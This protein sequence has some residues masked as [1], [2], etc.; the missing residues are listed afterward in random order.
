M[1]LSSASLP[2]S[3]LVVPT[4]AWL[5]VSPCAAQVEDYIWNIEAEKL[6]L[7]PRGELVWKA[8]AESAP[9]GN[10]RVYHAPVDVDRR[11]GQKLH[12]WGGTTDPTPMRGAIA[13]SDSSLDV[14]HFTHSGT[15]YRS[16]DH[17]G[18]LILALPAPARLTPESQLATYGSRI[19]ATDETG[20]FNDQGRLWALHTYTGVVVPPELVADRSSGPSATGFRQLI[21]V[22]DKEV[23][24]LMGDGT[25]SRFV[26]YV[27]PIVDYAWVEFP[28]ATQAL[29][30]ARH[31]QPAGGDRLVWATHN[32]AGT[33]ASFYSGPL[34][35]PAAAILLGA[36]PIPPS[37]SL[38]GLTVADSHIVYQF[39]SSG[40]G[41]LR[42]RSAVS[43]E[44]AS[45][46]IASLGHA[47]DQLCANDRFVCWLRN[48]N[49]IMRLPVGAA[50]ITRNLAL[51]GLE[52]IQAIQSPSN[53]VPLVADKPT[54]VRVLARLLASSAGETSLHLAPPVVLHGSRGGVPL[55]GSPLI[56]GLLFTLPPPVS[57]DAPNRQRQD[58]GYWFRLPESWITEGSVVLRAEL[59]P[60][61]TFRETSYA[62]NVRTHTATFTQKVPIGL[63]I[64]PTRTH[65]GTISRRRGDHR[66][67]FDQAA[68][69]LPTSSLRVEYTRTLI[70]ER[71][72]FLGWDGTSPY[73]FTPTDDD[74]DSVLHA[75]FWRKVEGAGGTLAEPGGFD[76]YLSLIPMAALQNV[77]KGY[78]AV[79]DGISA[80]YASLLAG[81]DLST[82]AIGVRYSA[83]V[84][85]HELGH[86]YGRAHVAGCGSPAGTD[87]SY[88]YAGGTISDE[89]AGHLGF[90]AYKRR[91]LP[92][93]GTGD[94]MSYCPASW[95]SDY[96]WKHIHNRV[97]TGYGPFS[98]SLPRPFEEGG[99]TCGLT[100]G[101]I[102]TATGSSTMR[103]VFD[104]GVEAYTR[105]LVNAGDPSG[106]YAVRAY[107][108]AV[109]K[110][111]FPARLFPTHFACGCDADDGKRV[112]MAALDD[113]RGVNVLRLVSLQ[114]P[115]APLATLAGGN[116]APTVAVSQPDGSPVA[117][118]TLVIQ[119]S[120]AD[121]GPGPLAHVVRVSADDGATWRSLASEFAGS[122]LSVPLAD[123]PGGGTCLV[124]VAASD[125]ILSG[126]GLSA[127]FSLPN[128]PPEAAILFE[129]EDRKVGTPLATAVFDYSE[130]LLLH[131]EAD[132][133][134]DGWLPDAALAWEVDGPVTRAGAGRR[135]APADLPPGSY[136]V[137][138]TATDSASAATLAQATLIV[139]NPYVEEASEPLTLDGYVE[140]PG[141]GADRW[142]RRLAY[143]G[144]DVVARV[145]LVH[146]S[147]A[148]CVAAAGLPTGTNDN[149]RFFFALDASG[150]PGAAPGAESLLVEVYATGRA[151]VWRGDGAG[152][153]AETNDT[154][155]ACALSGDAKRWSVE[156]R[157]PDEAL[158]GGF[159][160]GW[161]TFAFGA[162]D[163][164]A[165][166]D[167]AF[168]PAGAS[169]GQPETWLAGMLG[170][171]PDPPD[172]LDGDGMP[173]AWEAATFGPNG[174][175]QG[176]DSDQDGLDD[177][178]EYVAGTDP[179][180]PLS[181]FLLWPTPGH[182]IHWPAAAYRTYTVWRS[183]NLTD[184]AEAAEGLSS[185]PY[186]ANQWVDPDPPASRSF[187]KIEAFP[188][189]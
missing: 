38:I 4:L 108:N 156:L 104:L 175:N 129:N 120:S 23:I 62:D 71:D 132:D 58:E 147:N 169:P 63:K 103:P 31:R 35:N 166:G 105:A 176:Q 174:S 68:L 171:D 39:G 95:V 141:Y 49:T 100:G 109:L 98:T 19:Y 77:Y 114:T 83:I 124:E 78:G 1:N 118:D 116:A 33:A 70:E 46:E 10:S 163:R 125:G 187:Y 137:R 25:L 91:L 144:T 5:V 53:D 111:T 6:L 123:L 165:V 149:H 54:H 139:R 28:V 102:D 2:L 90:N 82:N 153:V 145:S 121:D 150:A 20:E 142:R 185:A 138:L 89:A 48:G 167:N 94:L 134:E 112:W 21:A 11:V 152:W 74:K 55:P 93:W 126:R 57:T 65:Y 43:F 119:W 51:V 60:S 30:I 9:S 41:P 37:T 113:L 135:F 106:T 85:A 40:G 186:G 13:V 181:R 15:I 22:T 50:A 140:E 12:P 45:E 158:P 168:F 17:S 72:G 99:I 122:S 164:T 32:A 79:G 180:S 87:P 183:T 182:T 64:I 188:C 172:D 84:L 115:G 160:G 69:L 59:N 8:N 18:G 16:S 67:L 80:T 7:T 86:N 75:L 52:T 128:H 34:S 136:A 26:R 110:S 179:L 101:I 29:A 44:I 151:A 161:G 177:A 148:L 189:R 178:G 36:E 42:R 73:E 97:G 155:I 173:D 96:T 146:D 24:A 61:R 107:S 154:G 162:L 130:R 14:Y 170:P 184:F 47:A 76:H 27:L 3:R 92:L 117:G 157:I 88:P 159:N 56:A 127:A 143:P 131:A 66:D 133:L 81:H